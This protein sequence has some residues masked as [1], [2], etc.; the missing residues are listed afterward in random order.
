[1]R[2]NTSREFHSYSASRKHFPSFRVPK[3]LLLFLLEMVTVLMLLLLM[4]III[5]SFSLPFDV[6]ANGTQ[7]ILAIIQYRIFRL[8][9]W[10]P[11]I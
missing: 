9:V 11:K 8:P 4:I 7:G 5:I 10:Y 2:Q 1:M 6:G 3:S